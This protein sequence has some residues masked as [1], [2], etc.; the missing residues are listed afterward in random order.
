AARLLHGEEAVAVD[1]HVGG[2]RSRL[3]GAGKRV[4]AAR[5]RNHAACK[6]RVRA[7][8][9]NEV[10]EA[11]VDPLEAGRLR[12][13]DVTGNVFQRVRVGPQSCNGRGQGAEDTH[14]IISNWIRAA[15]GMFWVSWPQPLKSLQAACQW[16]YEMKSNR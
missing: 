2:D 11:G 10:E 6:L 16:K 5:I 7:G 14:Y 4:G 8:V 13:R 9:G 3:N 1:R 15:A 12:V